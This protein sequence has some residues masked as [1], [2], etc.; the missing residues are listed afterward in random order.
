MTALKVSPK[1]WWYP[2]LLSYSNIWKWQLRLID[3]LPCTW[4]YS[5]FPV[6][7]HSL[8]PHTVIIP[9]YRGR[10][11]GTEN[12]SNFLKGFTW[13]LCGRAGILTL[14]V[15]PSMSYCFSI[16]NAVL[17]NRIIS[18]CSVC[19]ALLGMEIEKSTVAAFESSQ[20]VVGCQNSIPVGKMTTV[21][22]ER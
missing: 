20:M 19:L 18:V 11:W 21:Y 22:S 17:F 1:S 12:W 6:Y 15:G 10:I 4:E 3:I 7:I 16:S 9:F 2:F 13:L 14:A 5:Q 8:S